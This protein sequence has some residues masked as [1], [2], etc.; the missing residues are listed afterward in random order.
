MGSGIPKKNNPIVKNQQIM[1]KVPLNTDPV[2][3]PK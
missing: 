1:L 2:R 3:T